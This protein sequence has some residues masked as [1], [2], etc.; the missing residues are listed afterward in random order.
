MAPAPDVAL[1]RPDVCGG[2][3]GPGGPV[4]PVSSA[5]VDI[6]VE[7]HDNASWSVR[8]GGGAGSGTATHHVVTVPAGYA[9]T[10][11]CTGVGD[12]EL[13]RASFAF[14]L[15]R[16]P[17]GAI[18]GHFDLTVIPKYF[19]E[20]ADTVGRYIRAAPGGG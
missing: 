3:V 7:A 5:D 15:E 13:V 8:V 18:L 20:Y 17:A 4:S 9:Q 2:G 19:P 11:G 6:R 10:L 1:R 12:A 14:L 16:E